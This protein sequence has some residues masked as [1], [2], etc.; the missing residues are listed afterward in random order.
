MEV[1]FKYRTGY[2]GMDEEEIVEFPEDVSEEELDNYAWYGALQNAESFGIYP[3]P[4]EEVEDS[5]QYSN[6]IEGYWGVL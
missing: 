5:Q 4:E 3:Y 2:C 1:R 6:N